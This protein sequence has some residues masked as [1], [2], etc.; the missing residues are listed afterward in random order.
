M[1]KASLKNKWC[2]GGCVF[3][4]YTVT[5]VLTFDIGYVNLYVN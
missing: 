3:F 2:A 1:V 4:C 5:V